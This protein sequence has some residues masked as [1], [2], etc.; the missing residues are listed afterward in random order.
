[1][2]SALAWGTVTASCTIEAFGLEGLR[3]LDMAALEKRLDVFRS[4]TH[5]E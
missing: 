2:K 3:G 4:A 5:F 1:M